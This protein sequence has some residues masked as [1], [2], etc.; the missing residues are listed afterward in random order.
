MLDLD[1]W[2]RMPIEVQIDGTMIISMILNDM[3]LILHVLLL[4]MKIFI[5]RPKA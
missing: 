4:G 2:S 5:A 3:T 1:G